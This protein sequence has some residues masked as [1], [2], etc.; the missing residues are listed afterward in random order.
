VRAE[1]QDDFHNLFGKAF[2]QAY[3]QQLDRLHAERDK[4]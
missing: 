1:A 3:E 4:P 2:L